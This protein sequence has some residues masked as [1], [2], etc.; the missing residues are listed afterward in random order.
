MIE[1]QDITPYGKKSYEY[2]TMIDV[3]PKHDKLVLHIYR[4]IDKPDH[5]YLSCP[6]L[7]IDKQD[8]AAHNIERAQEE[9][10]ECI[11]EYL[12]DRVGYYTAAIRA[13]NTPS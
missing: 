9:A 8:L 1:W 12:S 10:I 2:R 13:L 5:W 3:S 4:H 6:N 11:K 7:G